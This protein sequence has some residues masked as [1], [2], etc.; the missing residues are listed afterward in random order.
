MP[1]QL[2]PYT[3]SVDLVGTLASVPVARELADGEIVLQ[4]RMK[5]CVIGEPAS[6]VPCATRTPSVIRKLEKCEVGTTLSLHG[7]VV[8]RFWVSAGATGSR[9]EVAVTS[10]EK[11]RIEP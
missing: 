11:C 8:S 5:I 1:Q 10:A 2:L 3:N 6:S 9:V 4:W 7:S